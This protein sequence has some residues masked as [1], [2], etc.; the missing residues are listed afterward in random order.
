MGIPLKIRPLLYCSQAQQDRPF[1]IRAPLSPKTGR[2]IVTIPRYH[3]FSGPDDD[4]VWVEAVD[5]L[6]KAHDRMKKLAAAFPGRFFI[7]CAQTSE[8]IA[9]IN[10]SHSGRQESIHLVS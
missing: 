4:A 9:S 5:A 7:F 10:T 3:I 8:I 1:V 2:S 6:R